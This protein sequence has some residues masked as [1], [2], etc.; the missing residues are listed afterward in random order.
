M[1]R[2]PVVIAHR[3]ASGYLPEHTLVAKA[4]AYGMRPDFIE[5]DVVLTKDGVPVVLHDHFLDTVTDVAEVYP[6]RKRADGRY[7][8]I[9]FTLGEIRHLTVHERINLAT[10]EAAFPQRFPLATKIPLFKVPTLEEEI[11]LIQGL[12]RST[13][14]DVGL[15]VELKSP[16]FHRQE[17]RDITKVVLALLG[18][19]GYLSRDANLFIQSFDPVCLKRIRRENKNCP[20]LVQLIGGETWGHV[21]GVE[22]RKQLTRKG[23][24]EIAGYADGLGLSITQLVVLGEGANALRFTPVLP[25]AHQA[26]LVVHPYTLR[27]DALAPPFHTLE[28]ACELLFMELKVDGI[29]TDFPDRVVD[30]LV[31]TGMRRER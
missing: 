23:L 14:R 29:F 4:M 7:Y 6:A 26:G 5:Q 17:G 3:G 31:R 18:R 19:H 27:A 10:G 16:W 12:N 22:F 15:Y 1:A 2:E 30:F 11:L 24:R 25:W 20:R 9:D 8:V 21:P 28:E 13:G